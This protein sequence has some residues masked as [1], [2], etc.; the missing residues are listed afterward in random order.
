MTGTVVFDADVLGRRRTGEE[1][2]AA[3]LLRGL[4]RLDTGLRIVALTRRPDL[5]PEGI[6]PYRLDARLQELRMAVGVPRALHRL[7][8]DLVHFQHVLPPLHRGPGVVTVHDVS[9][10]RD[11]TSMGRL[12]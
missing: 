5:V 10:A 6:E 8:P 3:S 9:Y 4:G 7:R 1:T 11:R 12:D 2:H